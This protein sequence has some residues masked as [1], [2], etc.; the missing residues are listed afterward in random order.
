V[1]ALDLDTERKLRLGTRLTGARAAFDPTVVTELFQVSLIGHS[2]LSIENCTP[3]KAYVE[4]EQCL[5]RYSL[6][7]RDV[8]TGEIRSAVLTGRLFA[9]TA[10]CLAFFHERVVP[11][12][13]RVEG[14]EE[15]AGWHSPMAVFE[16]LRLVV[17]AF[18]IDPDLPALIDATEPSRMSELLGRLVP[19]S[20]EPSL[21]VE[22]CR[23]DVAHY[24]RR[25]R[26][27]LRY[28]VSGKLGREETSVV[29]YGKVS[30]GEPPASREL[31]EQLG[32][33]LGRQRVRVPR[34]VGY[35]SDLGLV[36]IEGIPG[37]PEI[38]PLI[39]A[40]AGGGHEEQAQ[41]LARV[42]DVSA[43]VA[44]GV[45][46][47]CARP[48]RTRSLEQEVSELK[49]EI[50]ALGRVLPEEVDGFA[51]LLSQVVTEAAGPRP[52]LEFC[53]GDF[54][55]SQILFDGADVG[56]IDFDN[57]CRAERALD[58]GQFCAYMTAAALKAQRSDQATNELGSQLRQRFLEAYAGAAMIADVDELGERVRPY[59]R[60]SLLRMTVR[61]RRQLK[62]ARALLA[63][64]AFEATG[65]ADEKVSEA[66]SQGPWR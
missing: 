24:P 19:G 61:A 22:G 51:E 16:D 49:E 35:D 15:I 38:A 23:I 13:R 44:A 31:I 14:R 45:H 64:E 20:L 52:A 32:R 60:L 30:T 57:L 4:A 10:A 8:E 63:L 12:G 42:V 56:L 46:S 18:P 36:L 11:L 27:V 48:S 39:K 59:E 55:P 25:N 17:Y 28:E 5:L 58:L 21:E 54:T 53:H 6:K 41:A 37:R 50:E 40:V 29:A 9:D 43:Q 66:K 26:C 7:L 1:P 62:T 47:T 33:E 2:N 65:G 34:Y 3:G